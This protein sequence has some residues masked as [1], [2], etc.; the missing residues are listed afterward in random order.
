M[1]ARSTVGVYT[2]IALLGLGVT[3]CSSE[4][5]T[6]STGAATPSSAVSLT[7]CPQSPSGPPPSGAP[8]GAPSGPPA[9]A[10]PMAKTVKATDTSSSTVITPDGPGVRCGRTEVTLKQNLTYSTPTTA[11]GQKA[12]LKLD[13]QVP[14]TSGG[15]PPLVV[16]ITGGGF[17]MADKSANLG[18]RTYVA[19]Q[20]Y[21]VA[22][23]EYRTGTSGS[24]Y[25]D[26]VADVKSAVRYLRAHADEYGFDADKVAVWGQSAGGYLAAM[27][28]ATNGNKQFD[29]GDN[30]DRSSDVQAVVDEFGASD[31]A[32]IADDFDAATKAAYTAPGSFINAYVFGP[33]SKQTV[34]SDAAANEA[35]DP[36]TYLSASCAPFIL[37]QGDKDQIISPSQSLTLLNALKDKGVEGT[38]Y[39]VKGANHGDM[40]FLGDPT[41]G[42][43]WSTQQVMGTITDFLNKKLG[44]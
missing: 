25:K 2:G 18:E 29:S 11:A 23:I 15:K 34:T 26:G 33:G 24:T 44:S 35:A 42:A 39:V 28:G 3:A 27:A 36:A 20:G 5:S 14:K 40:S 4:S 16:Y 32:T 13:L 7:A 1:S 31:L 9:G 6:E 21:A 8:S 12:D 41:A 10:I 22:S 19:E 43:K 17:V 38:R 30:L 37:L